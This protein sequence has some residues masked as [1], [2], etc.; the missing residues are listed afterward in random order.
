MKDFIFIKNDFLI[1]L[2]DKISICD[3]D[4]KALISN[5][6]SSNAQI[7]APEINFYLKNS[8]DDYLN[9]AKNTLLL[10]EIRASVYDLGLDL[11][12]EKQ[13]G[14]N[15]IIASKE[16]KG[17]LSEYLKHNGFKVLQINKALAVY[18][19]IGELSV[20]SEN[21]GEE[22]EIECD[23]FLYDEPNESFTRQSGCY[24]LRKFKDKEH[25]R[26][27]LQSKSP[28]YRYKNFISYDSSI[29]QY[30]KRR[31]ECCGK[32]ALICPTTAIIKL[33]ETKELDF[34]MP[35]CIG[36]G[37]CVSICP[38]GS[39]EFTPLPKTSFYALLNFYEGKKILIIDEDFA[40]EKLDIRLDEGFLPLILKSSQL[41]QTQLLAL[42][43]SS[44]ANLILCATHFSKGNE[45]ACELLNTIFERKFGKKAVF[46]A[47]DKPSLQKALDSCEFIENLRFKL[48]QSPMLKREEFAKRLLNLIDENDFGV[49]ES[50]EWLRYGQ[51]SVNANTCTLCLACVGACNV[52][53][54]VADSKE[55]ALKFNPSLCTTCG[56][57][58]VSC[59]EKDTMSMQRSGLELKQSFFHFRTLAKDELFACVECGKAFA[60]TKAVQK[61]ANVMKEQFATNEKKLKTLYCC[62]ECKAKLMIFE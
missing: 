40:L 30:A 57:C 41:N 20:V 50:G 55:N 10:Y 2:P 5:E 48:P 13:V 26:D 44:G 17:V 43:Q 32:C 15:I 47:F 7:Y 56:Y 53:A 14:V 33:D 12:Y 23:L 3:K 18:G 36:C 49:V 28:V 42:L 27:F 9:K 59:A 34:S 16:N 46:K 35:D 54:L 25:L 1:P 11:E 4:E 24:N 21:G 38:S 19:S 31:E 52:G 45:E 58:V 6:K 62:A 60:T 61:V 29:C 51:V 22:L 8:Q 39:L 37:D